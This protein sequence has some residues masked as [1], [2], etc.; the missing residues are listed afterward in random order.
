MNPTLSNTQQP[1]PKSRFCFAQQQ[2]A[3]VLQLS[4]EEFLEA[5][6]NECYSNPLLEFPNDG[7]A[8]LSDG[9]A[10]SYADSPAA[11]E[12]SLQDYLRY[13]L[14]ALALSPRQRGILKFLI[15]C[16][17][18]NG[19]LKLDFVSA[20]AET[21]ASA[22]E[23]AAMRRV[24]RGMDPPGI[25]ACDLVQCLMLQAL[26]QEERHMC[27]Y[28]LIKYHLVDLAFNRIGLIAAALHIDNAEVTGLIAC[29]KSMNP[30]PGSEFYVPKQ[31]AY[32]IPELKLCVEEDGSAVAAMQNDIY[33][34]PQISYAYLKT[35][36][37]Q[38]EE[39]CAF[40]R[41]SLLRAKQLISGMRKRHET[42]QRVAQYLC[43][44]QRDY[45]LK[46]SDALSPVRMADA[47]AALSIHVSTV[48]RAV[49]GKYMETPR[50]T[51]A[52]KSLFSSA[53]SGDAHLSSHQLRRRIGQLVAAENR[54][55]PYSDG[56]LARLLALEGVRVTKRTVTNCRNALGI[57]SSR[58]RQG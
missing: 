7:A 22:S 41:R 6:K 49:N 3:A 10:L 24:L 25:G 29:I 40:L 28:R 47:A 33:R 57:P 4:T 27:L 58:D 54:L 11:D 14:G 30:K 20:A 43:T 38:D 56:E 21:G 8:F 15:S 45:L 13:Q 52:L 16:V 53:V 46:R 50:G 5:I 32:I 48:S 51:L 19:Y 23:L 37:P 34:E 2:S 39:A 44:A 18:D 12:M 36:S 55:A 31:S 35:I 9:D 42:V 1:V 26:R 17:D